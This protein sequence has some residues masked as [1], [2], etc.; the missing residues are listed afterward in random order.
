MTRRRRDPH[1]QAWLTQ[2]FRWPDEPWPCSDDADAVAGRR[3]DSQTQGYTPKLAADHPDYRDRVAVPVMAAV[4]SL[5]AEYRA[6]VRDFD[7]VDVYRAWKRRW[8]VDRIRERAEAA[9][10]RFVL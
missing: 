10:G 8:P 3:S 7:Y 1:R 6:C 2:A 4:D 5:P 9:G